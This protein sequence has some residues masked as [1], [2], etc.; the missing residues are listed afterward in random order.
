MRLRTR[1]L[2]PT[3]VRTFLIL[4]AWMLYRCTAGGSGWAYKKK[5]RE[6][7]LADESASLARDIAALG[8]PGG[9]TGHALANDLIKEWWPDAFASP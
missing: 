9:G 3:E 5:A 6:R 7:W 4:R 1:R 2:E 8:A